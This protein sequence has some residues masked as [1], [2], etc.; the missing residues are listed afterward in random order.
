MTREDLLKALAGGAKSP[1]NAKSRTDAG[2]R[3]STGTRT[4]RARKAS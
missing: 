3:T 4:K 2:S 1:T